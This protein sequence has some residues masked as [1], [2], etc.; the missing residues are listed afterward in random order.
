MPSGFP[1]IPLYP[2]DYDTD[3]TLFK[4]YNTSES[5]TTSDIDALADEVP[6]RP[7]RANEFEIWADNG[8][9]N[10]SGELFYYDGV[11]K[12]S[13]GKVC[14]LNF[15]VIQ[16]YYDIKFSPSLYLLLS[17]SRNIQGALSYTL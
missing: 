2:T 11:R 15:L 10:I 1:P 12:N 8:Y 13:N 16:G 9:A 7:R 5:Q 4:V 14:C 3:Y 17:F 6:I